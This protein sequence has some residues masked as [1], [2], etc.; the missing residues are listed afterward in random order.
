MVGTLI[1]ALLGFAFLSVAY[2]RVRTGWLIGPVE[3]WRSPREARPMRFWFAVIQSTAG[4]LLMLA[5]A[6]TLAL[7]ALGV[8]ILK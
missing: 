1:F 8:L 5:I 3:G 2:K 6:V 4:G 7:N